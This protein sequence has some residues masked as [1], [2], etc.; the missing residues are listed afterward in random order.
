MRIAEEVIRMLMPSIK[1]ASLQ[2]PIEHRE[3][4]EQEIYLKIV[5]KVNQE[6]L[7]E[8]P[9]FFEVINSDFNRKD[10]LKKK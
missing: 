6:N 1:K 8:L 4:L 9:N 5:Q 10:A 3:D 2:T 7:E